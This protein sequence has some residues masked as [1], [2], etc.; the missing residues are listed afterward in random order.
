MK[1]RV[2]LTALILSAFVVAPAFAQRGGGGG[3]GRGF[4]GGPQKAR[5]DAMTETFKLEKEQRKQIKTAIDEA[6]KA[7]APIR[8]ELAKARTALV[9]AV[10]AGKPQADLDEA[11]KAYG[12]QS[13]A[14][15]DAEMKALAQ[16]IGLLNPEQAKNNA[17]VSSAFF[18]MKGAF[19]DDKKWD[20]IPDSMKGY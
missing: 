11:A 18:L 14:L 10:A 13:A 8:A 7:A 5:M 2:T 15:A 9:A 12:A 4:G 1:I 16:M 3:G 20:D 19:I 6:F 17:A